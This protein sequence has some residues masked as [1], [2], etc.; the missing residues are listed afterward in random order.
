MQIFTKDGNFHI[1]EILI[2]IRS[3]TDIHFGVYF[4]LSSL[5]SDSYHPYQEKIIINILNDHFK[6]K[7]GYI[8]VLDNKDIAVI[9]NGND[10]N[11][12][13]QIVF[14]IKNLF[15]D[16]LSSP[17]LNEMDNQNFSKV[18][19]TNYQWQDFFNLCQKATKTN[20]IIKDS[21]NL[22]GDFINPLEA[23][24]ANLDILK[25]IQTQIICA[26][27]AG[28][29]DRISCVFQEIFV[30][31]SYLKDHLKHHMKFLSK[32]SLFRYFT[33]KLD[34]IV[35]NTLKPRIA[36]HS[37]IT[38]SLNLNVL[39]VLSEA[40]DDFTKALS[41]ANKLS[42]IIEIDIADLFSDI[43]AYMTANQ[44][45]K[46]AGYRTCLDGLNNLSF[47][48][49]DKDSLG[50][51]LVKLQWNADNAK[52]LSKEENIH[53]VQSVKKYG[54]NRVILCRCD[55]QHALDYGQAL[56]ISLFQGWHLDHIM[57]KTKIPKII[58]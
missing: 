7:E 21:D 8:I 26:I 11:L 29:P 41:S 37:N 43:N 27:P 20:L 25:A 19:V 34:I 49:V 18:F 28:N 5:Q 58:L 31:I 50:C 4:N 1:K 53:L 2:N 45:L 56:G 48:Q 23:D 15:V 6:D 30:S 35:L 44:Y 24:L 38:I 54:P 51:D 14:Q 22:Y 57:D 9:Y 32:K 46:K 16:D 33:E 10:K 39:T 13:D 36:L 40:F 42:V 47:L 52:A 12:V 17:S 3:H 55:N